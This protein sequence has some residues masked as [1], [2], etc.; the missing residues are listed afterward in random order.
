MDF[1]K[2]INEDL[3][4]SMKGKAEGSELRISTLR[5]MKSAVKNA[6]IAKRG[7]GDLT[8]EDIIGVLSGMVKQRKESVE[9]YQKADRPSLAEKENKE[10]NIIQEYLPEQLTTEELNEIIKST[11]R[12]TGV[13]GMKEIG[14]LMKELMP[15]VKGRADGKVVS[16]RIKE[17]LER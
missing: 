17:I 7:K 1:L 6:E 8:D 2:K 10:I 5:M 3:I 9:Q 13:T 16:T 15:K 11:I 4:A 14:R 12:E